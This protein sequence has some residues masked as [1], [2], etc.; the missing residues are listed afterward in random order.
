MG[1][2]DRP[3]VEPASRI[4]VSVLQRGVVRCIDVEKPPMEQLVGEMENINNSLA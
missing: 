4:T 3:A 2:L 1:K